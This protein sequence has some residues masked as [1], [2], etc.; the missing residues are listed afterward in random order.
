MAEAA[1]QSLV[2]F[3]P[4]VLRGAL[5]AGLVP[6]SE[7]NGAAL[8][9]DISG[10]TPLTHAFVR[11]FGA[12]RGS[13][14]LVRELTRIFELQVCAVHHHGGSVIGFGGDAITC[15]FDEPQAAGRALA[16]AM[17]IRDQLD[18][19]VLTLPG[20]VSSPI[21]VKLAIAAGS[22]RLHLLGDP[23]HRRVAV[24]TGATVERMAAAER[25]AN[26]GEIIVSAEVAEAL[27][28]ELEITAWREQQGLRGAVV[29]R[30]RGA[31]DDWRWPQEARLTTAQLRAWVGA[32]LYPRL[33][34]DGGRYLGAF[35]RVA[36]LFLHFAGIDY[37]Q[38]AQAGAVLDAFLR[39]IQSLLH[40]YGGL[41]I[42]VNVGDKGSYLSCAFGALEAHEDDGRRAITAARELLDLATRRPEVREISVGVAYAQVY[43]GPYGCPQRQ[44]FGMMGEEVILAARLMAAA[45]PGQVLASPQIARAA[46]RWFRFETLPPRPLKGF[47]Q[48]IQPRLLIGEKEQAPEDFARTQVIVGRQSEQLEL[49][50][51]LS[52][53]ATGRARRLLIEGEAGMGKST[54]ILGLR[55]QADA[56]G[57]RLL[58]GGADAIHHASPYHAWRPV[59]EAACG[60]A[61]GQG[62]SP[63]QP[64]QR[65]SRCRAR[66]AQL[67]GSLEERAALLNP[68]LG[69]TFGDSDSTRAL[70]GAVRA[71]NTREL[72]LDILRALP[73][74]LALVIEDLHWCDS[75]SLALLRLVAH[76]LESVLL[77]ATRRPPEAGP[78]D[79]AQL[80]GARLLRLGAMN[81]TE[82]AELLRAV[83]D[84]RLLPPSLV[85]WVCRKAEG[86]PFFSRELVFALCE[87]GVV[88][89]GGAESRLN[90]GLGNLA[91]LDFPDTIQGVISSRL[92]QLSGRE[93]MA[94][95]VAS[96]IGRQFA[97]R[98][99]HDV[100]PVERDR[101]V[102]RATLRQ[103]RNAD[104]ARELDDHRSYLFTHV[105][106]QEV[107]YA[108][109]LHEQ[110]GRL[111]QAVGQWIE[112]HP[113]ADP[114]A[115]LPLLAHHY[116]RAAATL[117]GAGELRQ[118]AMNCLGRAGL[119]ALQHCL[120]REA[121]DYFTQALTLSDEQQPGEPL[122]WHAGL[123]HA[124]MALGQ[125]QAAQ[126]HALRAFELL[127]MPV[128]PGAG[129]RLVDI[130]KHLSRIVW[131]NLRRRSPFPSDESAPPA[132]T[133]HW[134][135]QD[136]MRLLQVYS[137]ALFH[138][139]DIA[140]MLCANLR[141]LDAA[142]HVASSPEAA[143]AYGHAMMTLDVFKAPRLA[144]AYGERAIAIA[145]AA[146]NPS[147]LIALHIDR[148]MVHMS[149]ARWVEA[150][151]DFEQ[152]RALAAEIGD[153][154]QWGEAQAM[155]AD[156]ALMRGE[157]EPAEQL[158]GELRRRALRQDSTVQLAWCL[159]PGVIGL[160]DRGQ[161]QA[162]L[163]LLDEYQPALEATN[164]CLVRI[165]AL[166]LRA[167]AQTRLGRPEAT[168]MV[169][170]VHALIDRVSPPVA[171]PRYFG[172][173]ALADAGLIVCQRDPAS[174]RARQQAKTTLRY[175]SQYARTFVYAQ[176]RVALLRA[177]LGLTRGPAP[178]ARRAIEAAGR[179]AEALC[180]APEKALADHLASA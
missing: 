117:R 12:T 85:D 47:A 67:G 127:G 134:S 60:L 128:P 178:A 84:V 52:S 136:P 70:Q 103:L 72:I 138:E 80:P 159:R 11:A 151:R 123:A 108:Q 48:E 58:L 18:G 86:S 98:V 40:R 14:E 147:S 169:D 157:L 15:W 170:E 167:L 65:E 73:G 34:A 143:L 104:I 179:Q 25:M 59:L 64:G 50:A 141:S 156:M 164:E 38:D 115:D 23:L 24:I 145:T 27:A 54:L 56:L 35:R 173:R 95:K 168:S 87:A 79:S 102:L 130:L 69:L 172:L 66:L 94:V 53:L 71:D 20:G 32:Q 61:P 46:S 110:R 26:G 121:L 140:G 120:N 16:V 139:N 99:L 180:L 1:P 144:E 89:R 132:P 153:H 148:A 171:Y 162:A 4:R 90:L 118:K 63:E 42:D 31:V 29:A 119:Q 2:A 166:G 3:I 45:A 116:A 133:P 9:V 83:L 146:Q 36:A 37:E 100:H 125:F 163:D 49:E 51:A 41:L 149:H 113:S 126:Q 8:F 96:V 107:A 21:T 176:P 114:A 101:E 10:F 68:V 33:L 142:E 137:R 165:D 57:V 75:A 88:S 76:E 74:P 106:T 124:H 77:V 7:R 161:P 129:G 17:T 22:A 155:L 174:R 160:L 92:D 105:L 131:R 154:W 39:E 6:P 78:T 81:E 122:A 158:Y 44:T 175:L 19:H 43:A 150:A 152:A 109:L 93:L 112:A 30:W 55:R 28:A 62:N 111:H 13:E 5:A 177:G 82:T 97:A 91:E 135:P